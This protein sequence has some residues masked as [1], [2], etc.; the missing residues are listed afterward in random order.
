MSRSG[1]EH[2]PQSHAVIASRIE[3]ESDPRRKTSLR[4]M[5]MGVAVMRASVR[6]VAGGAVLH[7]V[8]LLSNG[9][10]PAAAQGVLASPSVSTSTSRSWAGYQPGT[11]WAYQGPAHGG[12]G[13]PSIAPVAIPVASTVISSQGGWAGYAPS[14]AWTGYR[15]AT[16]WQHGKSSATGRPINRMNLA[17]VP[18][19]SPYADGLVRSYREYG[20]GRPVPLIKP[21]LPGSP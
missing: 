6:V 8:I 5:S 9:L 13:K 15:P 14:S 11:A 20:T 16:A 12:I 18:G 2:T 17:H 10:A 19:P 21:W 4:L 7:L 3:G 1:N